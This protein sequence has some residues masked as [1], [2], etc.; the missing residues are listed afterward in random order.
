MASVVGTSS[1]GELVHA[2]AV[3]P[4]APGTA[5]EVRNQLDGRWSKGFEVAAVDADGYRIRR[6]SDG[7]ELPRTFGPES[8]RRPKERHRGTWWY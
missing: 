5:I 2:D 1:D 7:L 8:I 3:D 4:L 6:M